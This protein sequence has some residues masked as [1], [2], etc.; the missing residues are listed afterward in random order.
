MASREE[1]RS[2]KRELARGMRRKL[3]DTEALLWQ[4]LRASRL[5]GLHFR[6]QEPLF[7]FIADFYC[8][9]S[10]LDVEVDG[11]IHKEQVEYDAGR[12]AT[13]AAHGI[14]VLRIPAERVEN[15]IKSVLIQ[16]KEA[17]AQQV[18]V[19]PSVGNEPV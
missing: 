10:L 5:A 17:A 19:R 4:H 1:R 11:G 18:D 14:R 8:H 3:T 12:D 13:L 6:R 7:G 9:S 15:D 2:I 16:I